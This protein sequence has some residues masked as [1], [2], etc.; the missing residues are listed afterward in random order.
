MTPAP[1]LSAACA[2]LAL[3]GCGGYGALCEAAMECR[4]GNDADVEACLVELDRL[5]QRSE[6]AGCAEA[7][8]AL[9]GCAE[10]R[11]TCSEK[12]FSIPCDE[13]RAEWESCAE[14]ALAL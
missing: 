9:A 8:S 4:G 12:L 14:L 10:E 7:W 3:A 2:A 13:E 1:R 5:E 6:L 11:S